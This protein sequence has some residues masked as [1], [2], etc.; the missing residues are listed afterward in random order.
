[1]VKGNWVGGNWE[2]RVQSSEVA[3]LI[4]KRKGAMK[5][6]H[7]GGRGFGILSDFELKMWNVF[8]G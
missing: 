5:G 4:Q 6:C 1:M 3:F 7:G 2:F 8:A